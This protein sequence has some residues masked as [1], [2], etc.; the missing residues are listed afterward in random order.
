M[1]QKL[2][3]Y[4]AIESLREWSMPNSKRHTLQ[5]HSLVHACKKF[6]C[7]IFG[8][9]ITVF[10]DHKPLEQIF[11]RQLLSAP[12]RLQ[13]MLLALQWYDIKVNYN[14]GKYM[15]LPDTLSRAY[16][17]DVEQEIDLNQITVFEFLNISDEKYKLFQDRTAEELKK[18]HDIMLQGNHTPVRLKPTAGSKVWTPARI[19]GKLGPRSYAFTSEDGTFRRNSLPS[20]HPPPSQPS[21]RAPA[22]EHS[23]SG[24]MDTDLGSALSADPRGCPLSPLVLIKAKCPPSPE[25]AKAARSKKYKG[26]AGPPYGGLPGK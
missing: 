26:L 2:L 10:T 7:Y 8:K 4:I 11:K 16:L 15:Q 23:D 19:T 12:M 24:D 17:E 21:P 3:K 22:T 6:H 1:V 20:S 9:E 18:L 14:K 25:P 5:E 13:R